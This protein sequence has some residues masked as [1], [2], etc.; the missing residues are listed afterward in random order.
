M[1]LYSFTNFYLSSIQHGIQTA[2]CVSELFSKYTENNKQKDMLFEWSNNHKTI[3]CLNGGNNEKLLKLYEFFDDINNP[4]PFVKF[5]EDEKSLNQT[6][7]AV[8]IVL[9]EKIYL[10]AEIERI[11]IYSSIICQLD[12]RFVENDVY[13]WEAT[14]YDWENRYHQYLLTDWEKQLI[15]I[16]NQHKFA[17]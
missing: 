10:T 14:Y 5:H 6:L 4:Y 17:S 3:Y 2:H 8:S 11:S 13:R 12:D 7:T 9:P 15:T 16:L 1:R